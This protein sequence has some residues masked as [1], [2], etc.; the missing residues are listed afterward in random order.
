MPPQL[1]KLG[2]TTPI[3]NIGRI[4]LGGDIPISDLWLLTDLLQPIIYELL[5]LTTDHKRYLLCYQ[6]IH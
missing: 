1:L 6:A 4:L 3:C 2:I 5:V